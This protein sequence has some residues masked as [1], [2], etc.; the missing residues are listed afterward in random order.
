M[1]NPNN[2]HEARRALDI[3][4]NS[5]GSFWFKVWIVSIVAISLSLL[6]GNIPW[7]S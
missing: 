2:E 5:N 3:H 6:I 1:T 4:L 7:I